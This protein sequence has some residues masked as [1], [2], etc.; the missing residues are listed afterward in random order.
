[1]GHFNGVPY[2][3][4]TELDDGS[5]HVGETESMIMVW[6]ETVELQMLQESAKKFPGHVVSVTVLGH[7]FDESGR[8]CNGNFEDR[9]YTYKP[10]SYLE[11]E[12][13]LDAKR[14]TE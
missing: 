3:F 4:V 8:E 13:W 5:L 2:I 14:L 6:R 10:Y 7:W 12:A 11:V 1:M 9:P